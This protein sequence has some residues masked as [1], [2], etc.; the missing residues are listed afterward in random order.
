MGR[1]L[2]QRKWWWSIFMWAFDRILQNSY[3]LYKRWKEMHNLKPITHYDY[4]ES[5]ALSWLDSKTYWPSRYRKMVRKRRASTSVSTKSPSVSRVQTSISATS[6]SV[7][8][9]ASTLTYMRT[10]TTLPCTIATVPKRATRLSDELINN[11]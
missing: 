7:S 11:R 2:L 6:P 1:E 4:R 10:C 8:S 3:C 9:V 5:I